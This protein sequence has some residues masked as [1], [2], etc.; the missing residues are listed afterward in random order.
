M[1][2]RLESL[3]GSL[4]PV[5]ALPFGGTTVRGRLPA[6]ATARSREQAPD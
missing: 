4:D 3:G 5:T 2:E 6:G 1:T